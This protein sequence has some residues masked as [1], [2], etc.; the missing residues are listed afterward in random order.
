MRKF[1]FMAAMLIGL[2]MAFASSS[3]AMIQSSANEGAGAKRNNASATFNYM[4][5]QPNISRASNGDT[6]GVTG[7]GTFGVHPKSVSGG[8]AFTHTLAGGGT[9]S[10]TWTAD[11]LISFVP[12]GCGVIFGQPLPPDLCGGR[13]VT[14]VTL[15]PNGGTPVKG[16]L[17]ISCLIG[18]PPPSAKE[19]IRLVVPGVAN[20]NKRVEGM[21]LYV[22]TS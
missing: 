7:E 12:Y 13:M 3:V 22:K 18:Y 10:G 14:K 6:V 20:F 16:Q 5:E 21:N 15:T 19:G 8:G 1:S 2:V 11:R 4:L 9:V 17:T